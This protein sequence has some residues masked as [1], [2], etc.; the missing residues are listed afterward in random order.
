[1]FTKAQGIVGGLAAAALILA[2]AGSAEAQGLGRT[3]Y[4]RAPAYQPV[5]PTLRLP[6][7]RPDYGRMPGWDW[8]YMYPQ[9]YYSTHGYWPYPYPYV[10]P[11]SPVWPVNPY[12][13]VWPYGSAQR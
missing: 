1:M 10:N 3:A 13:P 4:G 7:P 5:A 12:Y 8:K 11:Y 2:L 9:V 6:V